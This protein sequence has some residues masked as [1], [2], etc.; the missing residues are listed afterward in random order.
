[1][2]RILVIIVTY[3][4]MKWIDKCLSSVTGQDAPSD[5]YIIDNC[6]TDGTPEYI[7]KSYP[8]VKI[9]CS[10]KNLGFGK[11][12][13]IGFKYAIENGYDYVYLLNQDAWVEKDTIQLLADA[14]DKCPEYGILSPM[15]M[16]ASKEKLD[17]NFSKWYAKRGSDSNSCN[18]ESIPFVMAAHWLV[19][20]K[21]IMETGGFSPAF[22]HYGED[23]N[24]IH[25]ALFH[26]FKV[27]ILP[28]AKAVHDREYRETT[29]EQKMRLKY[30][31]GVVR[32]SNPKNCLPWQL[33]W[34][35]VKL[36]CIG[37]RYCSGIPFK[38]A[39]Q[40]LRNYPA[41]IRLRKDS[42]KKGSFLTD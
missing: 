17:K 4:G 31:G 3:N 10:G 2:K 20:R 38:S 21:C 39:I 7:E 36:L 16:T 1:M 32:V 23:D 5:V 42:K 41:L 25:R 15:Q 27:G 35:P 28:S 12:N 30:I 6:S 13:N 22:P 14:M 11:A 33:I 24:Y 40:L 8:Q 37:I 18:I 19:S 26:S 9:Y 29:I 34:Q